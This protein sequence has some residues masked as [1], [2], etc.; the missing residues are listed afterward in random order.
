MRTLFQ[1]P[2]SYNK[3][4]FTIGKNRFKFNCINMVELFI[5]FVYTKVSNYA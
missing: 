2:P 1:N 3:V 5:F 4:I